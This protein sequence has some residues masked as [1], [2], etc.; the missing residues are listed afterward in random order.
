MEFYKNKALQT[1]IKKVNTGLH[2]L[3]SLIFI[4]LIANYMVVWVP[5]IL[6]G[7]EFH[8]IQ[9]FSCNFCFKLEYEG[10]K[11]FTT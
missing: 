2:T 8:S 11:M 3:N 7:P 5:G 4:F 10:P 9:L 1:C 6:Y